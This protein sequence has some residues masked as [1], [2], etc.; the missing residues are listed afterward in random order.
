M[1]RST[2]ARGARPTLA[3]GII[4]TLSC[5]LLVTAA[6]ALA[7]TSRDPLVQ[8]FSATSP[9]NTPLGN[10]AEYTAAGLGDGP[11]GIDAVVVAPAP[12]DAAA[13][14]L[15]RETCAVRGTGWL[16]LVDAA[17]LAATSH[18][19]SG[20]AA[21]TGARVRL[22]G[23]GMPKGHATSLLAPG[24]AVSA[25]ELAGER[26]LRHALAL[27][28]PGTQ[29]PA[30]TLLALPP[31][32]AAA[33]RPRT[34]TGRRLLAALR[35]YGAYVSATRTSAVRIRL[36][37]DVAAAGDAAGLPVLDATTRA[38]LATMVGALAVVTKR[39]R[40]TPPAAPVP[41]PSPTASAQ[42]APPVAVA[43]RP[44]A[45]VTPVRRAPGGVLWA[46]AGAAVV[47]LVVGLRAGRRLAR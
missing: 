20:G 11:V 6:P 45:D 32:L 25:A 17:T 42:V 44:V 39:P 7:A 29:L 41:A 3:G 30:G 35:D 19:C 47:L 40:S 37:T 4:C 23:T 43:A 36:R 10:E 12:P 24:G 28:V 18:R 2:A 15:V 22:T 38:D 21:G 31:G 13:A 46:L 9:W 14:R 1:R 5:L 16:V 33:L 8:P 26:P 34:A 27:S